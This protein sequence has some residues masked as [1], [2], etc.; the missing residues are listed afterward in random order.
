MPSYDTLIR[1]A[2]VVDGSGNP[3]T[4]G[5]V[6]LAGDRIAAVAPARPHRPPTSA[7]EVVDASGHVVCPGF[8][9]IQSHAILP[10][11]VDGRCLSKITQGVTTEIMGEAW[12]PAPVGGRNTDPDGGDA[13]R[14]A[15]RSGLARAGPVGAASATGCARWRRAASRPTSARSSAA[16]RCARTPRG[17]T[18]ARPT[19]TSS[20]SCGG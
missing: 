6:A 17:W 7:R 13:V 16:A 10:L 4:H 9:D 2:R 20:T 8:I 5:D 15:R 18:W 3:W 1:H 11:M 14:A 12:T 19:P